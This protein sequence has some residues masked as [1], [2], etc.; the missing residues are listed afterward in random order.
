MSCFALCVLC[1]LCGGMK[2]GTGALS[3][4]LSGDKP[5]R[6]RRGSHGAGGRFGKAPGI[7]AK[8]IFLDMGAATGV[9]GMSS[10]R[11]RVGRAV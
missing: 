4:R 5:P 7:G 9:Y 11:W 6:G 1:V 2:P 3:W 8:M 10:W